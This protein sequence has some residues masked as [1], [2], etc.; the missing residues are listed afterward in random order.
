MKKIISFICLICMLSTILIPTV[1]ASEEKQTLGELKSQIAS[2]KKQK[3]ENDKKTEEAK[4]EIK[5]KE[6]AIKQAEIDINNAQAEQERVE[7]EIEESNQKIKELEEEVKKV[8]LYLQQMKGQNAY[9]EYVSGAST[10]TEM[11]MRIAAVEQISDHIQ[12]TIKDLE[13][14]IKKNEELKQELIEKQETLKKQSEQ[15]KKAIEALYGDINNYDAY[16]LSLEDKIKQAEDTLKVFE[17]LCKQYA[18][19]LGDNAIYTEDCVAPPTEVNGVVVENGA[20]LKPLTSGTITS[21]V[22]T[23][24]GSYHNALDIGGPSPF[25]GTPVYAAAAGVVVGKIYENGC[26]GNMLFINVSVNGEPYTTY[27]YHLLRFNVN[28]GDVV[29]QNTIIGWA[30]G[31]STSTEHGGY[32]RCTTGAHLHF[33]VQK[34][35]YTGSINKNNVITPPG[36][37][38]YKGWS[39]SS[40]YQMYQG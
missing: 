3:E 17:P 34:G 40:R 37:P 29:T 4:A 24:W 22:G 30:G 36:F 26:G 35:Y 32:D 25:E 19:K 33:G 23:R 15:Y 9:V 11:I 10:V 6:A 21:T 31:Y 18:S 12:K 16:E 20:W 27:Y 39:F 13:A 7:Q 14:E 5:R 28:K 8:L 1:N 2:L 38:N